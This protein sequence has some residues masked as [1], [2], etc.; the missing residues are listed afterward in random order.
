MTTKLVKILLGS[1]SAAAVAAALAAVPALG[2]RQPVEPPMSPPLLL[3]K[4]AYG[5]HCGQCHGPSGA[6]TDKGPPFLHRLY[7]P[8]H[9]NDSSFYQAVR[10]GARAHHFPFGDMKPLPEVTNEQ[11]DSIVRYIRALQRLNGVF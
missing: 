2:Q 6:G 10:R 8:D 1:L 5:I 4:M 11:I 7:R 9:H 3:G